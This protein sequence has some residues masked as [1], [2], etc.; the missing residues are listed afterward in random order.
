MSNN[1]LINHPGSWRTHS[2]RA[3]LARA[4]ATRNRNHPLPHRP[5]QGPQARPASIATFRSNTLLAN[6]SRC[7]L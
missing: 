4:S 6:A 3:G 2:G 1:S 5:I 7:F